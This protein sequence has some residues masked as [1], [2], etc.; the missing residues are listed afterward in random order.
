ML[1]VKVELVFGVSVHSRVAAQSLLVL[2]VSHSESRSV[3]GIAR[4]EPAMPALLPMVPMVLM[5]VL[6][7]TKKVFSDRSLD[8][9]KRERE[10]EKER[11]KE[12]KLW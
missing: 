10:G 12:V 1:E 11:E 3:S 8:C 7:L 5:V 9:E 2:C 4:A 6:L